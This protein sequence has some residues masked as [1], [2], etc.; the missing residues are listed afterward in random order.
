[1]IEKTH[2]RT[3]PMWIMY[4][5]MTIGHILLSCLLISICWNNVCSDTSIGYLG[6]ATRQQLGKQELTRKDNQNSK[7]ENANADTKCITEDLQSLAGS[8][9]FTL[10]NREPAFDAH[11]NEIIAQLEDTGD[12][13]ENKVA[14]RNTVCRCPL[15][16]AADVDK[17]Q[18]T[19]TENKNVA[20]QQLDNHR[21]DFDTTYES[22]QVNT[23]HIMTETDT[24]QASGGNRYAQI[25]S[26]E[27]DLL[28][29][30]I[31]TQELQEMAHRIAAIDQR[32]GT[33]TQSIMDLTNVVT[34]IGQA[35]T[36][37]L[38]SQEQADT[39][40]PEPD[41]L[42]TYYNALTS[43]TNQVT[44]SG[45]SITPLMENKRSIQEKH[46]AISNTMDSPAQDVEALANVT[47]L[48][49]QVRGNCSDAQSQQEL[50]TLNMVLQSLMGNNN[51]ALSTNLPEGEMLTEEHHR[52]DSFQ[53]APEGESTGNDDAETYELPAEVGPKVAAQSRYGQCRKAMQ[54]LI[55]SLM[56]T[57]GAATTSKVDGEIFIMGAI[58]PHPIEEHP[59]REFRANSATS[60][61]KVM[62]TDPNAMYLHEERMATDKDQV[63]KTIN[64]ESYE[65]YKGYLCTISKVAEKSNGNSIKTAISTSHHSTNDQSND[66]TSN[67]MS[68]K[69][70]SAA[71][72]SANVSII[73]QLTVTSYLI[74]NI[75]NS[76]TE[77]TANISIIQQ[78]IPQVS[79]R[80]RQ[81]EWRP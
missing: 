18:P 29:N 76:G 79:R 54:R 57:M 69:R 19:L 52:Q 28:L 16:Y 36:E 32:V 11:Q 66:N 70:K 10:I 78:S 51:L 24:Y 38:A 65:P 53:Q 20:Y 42:R 41:K 34:S 59:L 77:Q 55:L 75:K 60:D 35:L 62:Y 5:P 2:E 68:T 73:K 72:A 56:G 23:D 74:G 4:S 39:L 64:Q 6:G 31:M 14:A 47:D 50:D 13:L 61:P 22:V 48:Y 81:H 37:L 30:G 44:Q 27:Q 3:K 63:I 43:L 80:H 45:M 58:L 7:Q 8:K 46:V 33:S 71:S 17:L 21:T 49:N 15:A 1:M 40:L 12:L 9:K 67:D 26:L 25:D